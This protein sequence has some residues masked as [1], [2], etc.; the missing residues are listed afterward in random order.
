MTTLRSTLVGLVVM[1]MASVGSAEVTESSAQGFLVAHEATIAASPDEVYRV[2][3]EEVGSWWSPAHTF[4]GDAGNLSIEARPGGCF[5]ERLPGGGGVEHLRVVYVQ[6]GR[7]LRLAGGLGPLQG[8]GLTGSM[9]WSLAP[10]DGGTAVALTYSVGGFLP[11]GFEQLAPAVDGVLGEQL[12]RLRRL[13]ET[14][15]PSASEEG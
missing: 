3:V 15:A 8:S 13:V 5:C 9:T 6:P 4:S 10:T 7:V 14:G 11:G 1:G 2:L 12:G